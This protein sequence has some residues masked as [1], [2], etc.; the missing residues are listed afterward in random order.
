MSTLRGIYVDMKCETLRVGH[1]DGRTDGR[2]EGLID[3]KTKGCE[4]KSCSLQLKKD[5]RQ[6][7]FIFWVTLYKSSSI[8][9]YFKIHCCV[10]SITIL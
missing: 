9:G 7:I 3:R 6:Q 1:R 4:C 10:V 8:S 2:T 5:A